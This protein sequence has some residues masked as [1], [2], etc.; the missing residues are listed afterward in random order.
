MMVEIFLEYTDSNNY[1]DDF[2][3]NT[4]EAY[5]A[6]ST[7]HILITYYGLIKIKMDKHPVYCIDTSNILQA[8][9]TFIT[10]SGL[11]KMRMEKHPVHIMGTN[12]VLLSNLE[13]TN[14]ESIH[15]LEK[16]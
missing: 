16:R 14:L 7:T 8:I 9:N 4:P 6:T 3:R 1:N 11:I 12:L 10:Y 5:R 15:T 13:S 2:G